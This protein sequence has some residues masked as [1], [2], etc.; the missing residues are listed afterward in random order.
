M[1]LF[2]LFKGSTG[3]IWQGKNSAEEISLLNL[4]KYLLISY[5]SKRIKRRNLSKRS[6]NI[7]GLKM[8]RRI[9]KKLYRFKIIINLDYLRYQVL[10][11][12]ISK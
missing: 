7:S 5:L 6:K 1:W 8:L 10:L 9:F 3:G 2:C 11:G 4:Q 12:I